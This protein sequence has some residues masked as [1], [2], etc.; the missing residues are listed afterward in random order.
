M[1][2][3]VQGGALASGFERKHTLPKY[4]HNAVS[5]VHSEKVNIRLRELAP[6]GRG[7][8]G[9]GITKHNLTLLCISYATTCE[10]CPR[11]E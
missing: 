10:G 11:E 2:D 9:G 8:D 5:I 1:L 6:S 3:F 7:S 4:A